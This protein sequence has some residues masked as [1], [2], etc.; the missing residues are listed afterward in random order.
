M[1]MADCVVDFFILIELIYYELI[2]L[3]D[4]NRWKATSRPSAWYVKDAW[5]S[6]T[7]KSGRI[8][9]KFSCF[10]MFLLISLC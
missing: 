9:S 10:S 5:S 1:Q 4:E 2:L 7:L 8:M 6:P 3:N